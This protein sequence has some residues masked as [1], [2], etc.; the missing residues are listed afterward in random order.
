MELIWKSGSVDLG[1]ICGDLFGFREGGPIPQADD[2][3]MHRSGCSTASWVESG[4]IW[5]PC[6]SV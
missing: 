4:P 2:W 6:R 3:L 1:M 5:A